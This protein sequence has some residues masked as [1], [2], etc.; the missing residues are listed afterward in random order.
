MIRF[1]CVAE[2]RV[3]LQNIGFSSNH[4][5][6]TGKHYLLQ[7]LD[8]DPVLSLRTYGKV[9]DSIMSSGHSKQP[10]CWLDG[11]FLFIF[12][13]TCSQIAL[14]SNWPSNTLKSLYWRFCCEFQG[15]QHVIST[16]L[17]EWMAWRC[18]FCP[19]GRVQLILFSQQNKDKQTMHLH[20]T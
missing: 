6:D 12:L 9:N 15:V 10:W 13:S 8:V 17:A 5:I 2:S 19:T 4:P 3:L 1:T 16:V 20:E 14:F 18:Y 11:W 7:T